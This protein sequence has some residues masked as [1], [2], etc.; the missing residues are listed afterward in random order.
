MLIAIGV[1]GAAVLLRALYLTMKSRDGS[2]SVAQSELAED[3][4]KQ[5]LWLG[6]AICVVAVVFLVWAAAA[7]GTGAQAVAATL[8]SVI[9]RA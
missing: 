4:G 2:L 9:A 5:G 8:A 3:R 7:L 1:V 6:G